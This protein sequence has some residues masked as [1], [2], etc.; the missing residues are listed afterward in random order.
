VGLLRLIKAH[1]VDAL[2]WELT[3]LQ[4]RLGLEQFVKTVA[5]PMTMRVGEAWIAG[6][7][8]IFEEHLFTEALQGAMRRAMGSMPVAVA[9]PKILLTTVP[10]ERHSLGLLMAEALMVL[11]GC[12][13]VPCGT[14]MPIPEIVAAAHAHGVDVVALSCTAALSPNHVLSSLKALRERLSP[15]TEL[16]V[17]GRSPALQKRPV[18]GVRA[19]VDLD[20]IRR[21]VE[22]WRATR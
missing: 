19:I 3:Q 15:V 7:L 5:A 10:L 18:A 4:G 17:G 12:A 8:E 6:E 9:A 11:E 21:Q 22:R 16:W 13:C 1:D 2:R 14:E 20:D